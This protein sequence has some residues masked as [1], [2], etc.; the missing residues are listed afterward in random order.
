MICVT[1]VYDERIEDGF[2]G[3]VTKNNHLLQLSVRSALRFGAR[4]LESFSYSKR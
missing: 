3:F 1:F 4:K 2:H